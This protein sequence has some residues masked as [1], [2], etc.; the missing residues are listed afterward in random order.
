MLYMHRSPL[1]LPWAPPWVT[2]WVP[3][4]AGMPIVKLG[5][6]VLPV[7]SP[8]LEVCG[9]LTTRQ[10]DARLGDTDV[11][12]LSTSPHLPTSQDAAP[13]D[14]VLTALAELREEMNKLKRE[15]L[16]PAPMPS[17]VNEGASTSLGTQH[18]GSPVHNF[19]GFPDPVCEAGALTKQNFS[20]SVLMHNTG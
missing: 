6:V 5:D 20:D 9:K 16:P 19:A 14:V 3:G 10:A 13:W 4:P 17:R 7:V 1:A 12:K 8:G 18:N 2:P 11:N 15:R